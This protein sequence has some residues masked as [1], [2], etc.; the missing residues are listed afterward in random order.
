MPWRSVVQKIEQTLPAVIDD[1]EKNHL[2]YD[3]ASVVI[4]KFLGEKDK[5]WKSERGPSKSK[6]GSFT[7]WVVPLK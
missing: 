3:L 4:S 5:N 6:P 7:T 1:Q 2:A